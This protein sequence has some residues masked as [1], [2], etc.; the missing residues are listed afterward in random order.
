MVFLRRIHSLYWLVTVVGAMS[1]AAPNR[2]IAQIC[3]DFHCNC[4]WQCVAGK[5]NGLSNPRPE[6]DGDPD[7]LYYS[8][9]TARAEKGASILGDGSSNAEGKEPTSAANAT[10]LTWQEFDLVHVSHAFNEQEICGACLDGGGS[11][12]ADLRADSQFVVELW[13]ENWAYAAGHGVQR[14]TAEGNGIDVDCTATG[15]IALTPSGTSHW[16]A[17]WGFGA[18]WEQEGGWTFQGQG[19]G[20]WGGT[21]QPPGPGHAKAIITPL[22]DGG[23]SKERD[24]NRCSDRT[25]SPGT[26]RVTFEAQLTSVDVGSAGKPELI[27]YAPSSAAA[28]INTLVQGIHALLTCDDCGREKDWFL[29][30]RRSGSTGDSGLIQI[31]DDT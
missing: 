8:I 18:E 28:K 23:D 21:E 27:G 4:F 19:G 5:H 10:R 17:H 29:G 24:E 12:R 1:L 2:A 6:I 11:A 22:W 14:V 13:R 26:I 15:G 16:G 25:E 7:G 9:A 20:S 3:P 30:F 31:G